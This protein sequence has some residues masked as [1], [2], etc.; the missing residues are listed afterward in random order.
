MFKQGVGG[1]FQLFRVFICFI[2]ISRANG[3][4]D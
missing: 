1:E 2:D 4:R 3:S